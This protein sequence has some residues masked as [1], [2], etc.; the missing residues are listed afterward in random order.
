[1][2]LRDDVLL[3]ELQGEAVVIDL[4]SGYLYGLD[5]VAYRVW[6]AVQAT[7]DLDA[8]CER[9]VGAFEGVDRATLRRDLDALIAQ[10]AEAGLLAGSAHPAGPGPTG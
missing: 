1:M 9:L 10:L 3:R 4:A 2:A 5:A 8:A 6:Q 7:A